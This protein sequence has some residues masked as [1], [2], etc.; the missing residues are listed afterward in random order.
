MLDAGH[1]NHIL[2]QITSPPP[3]EI[4]T[5]DIYTTIGTI[6]VYAGLNERFLCGNKH[7]EVLIFQYKGEQKG[8]ADRLGT[9]MHSL[10]E[11]NTGMRNAVGRIC[12]SNRD[13]VIFVGYIKGGE[14]LLLSP[15]IGRFSLRSRRYKGS[16]N[17]S[18]Y[19]L[20][21]FYLIKHRK[22]L[23]AVT[24]TPPC[25]S[26]LNY[27]CSLTDPPRLLNIPLTIP[28]SLLIQSIFLLPVTT[29]LIHT[30]I[31]PKGVAANHLI[32]PRQ[33]TPR[34]L[35]DAANMEDNHFGDILYMCMS[36]G[37]LW[38]TMFKFT[39]MKE[40]EILQYRV[41]WRVRAVYKE[42]VDISPF[43]GHIPLDLCLHVDVGN[44]V[45]FIGATTGG[46]IR[47]IRD[48]LKDYFRGGVGVLEGLEGK[49]KPAIYEG[50][51]TIKEVDQT[52]GEIELQG[53]NI[54][55]HI[56]SDEEITNREQ[57]TEDIK[58]DIWEENKEV[59]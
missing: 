57:N 44:D 16:L 18:E 9:F 13:Q 53:L 51:Q 50:G 29:P 42:I 41:E 11:N 36:N 6:C 19:P 54:L 2:Y 7:G 8:K 28:P 45:L 48:T 59:D 15:N 37:S 10:S 38:S 17:M 12:C 56:P 58:F 30:Y 40:E 22:I 52:M 23:I 5:T 39:I 47:V 27:I 21:S 35:K 1:I 26:M 4:A 34:T 31:P 55:D 46:N 43:G 33:P 32:K 20:L 49:N 3:Q 14:N 24:Q 25:I